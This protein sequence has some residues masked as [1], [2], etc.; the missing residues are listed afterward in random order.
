MNKS[1][2]RAPTNE[3]AKRTL[4]RNCYERVR[5]RR[6]TYVR[7]VPRRVAEGIETVELSSDEEDPYRSTNSSTCRTSPTRGSQ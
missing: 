7:G 6:E 4:Q 1:T 3:Q 2:P 5:S